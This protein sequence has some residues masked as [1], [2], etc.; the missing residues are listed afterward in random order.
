MNNYALSSSFEPDV[1]CYVSVNHSNT[2]AVLFACLSSGRA[3]T[4]GRLLGPTYYA[5]CCHTAPTQNGSVYRLSSG[6][7]TMTGKQDGKC[8]IKCLFHGHNLVCQ[9][10][11]VVSKIKTRNGTSQICWNL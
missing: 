2:E 10:N 3:T 11:L 9:A 8:G 6:W 7:V 4:T 5:L 1:V